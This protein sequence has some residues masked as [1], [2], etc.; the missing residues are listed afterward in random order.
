MTVQ[1]HRLADGELAVLSVAP[2]GSP[3]TRYKGVAWV[4]IGPPLRRATAEEAWRLAEKRRAADLPFDS[5][6]APGAALEALN[7]NNFRNEHLANAI[8]APVQAVQS[9]YRGFRALAARVV[10]QAKIELHS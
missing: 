9:G 8:G 7:L 6:P 5:R 2:S 10:E 1:K 4:R 3:P